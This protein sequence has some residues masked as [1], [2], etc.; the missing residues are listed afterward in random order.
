MLSHLEAVPQRPLKASALLI[1]KPL[2]LSISHA[3]KNARAEIDS[4]SKTMAKPHVRK[5]S[6][7]HHRKHFAQVRR[8]ANTRIAADEQR[9]PAF[10]ILQ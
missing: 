10:F 1:T 4:R 6:E 9:A 7:A 5:A 8:P 3:R 2:V